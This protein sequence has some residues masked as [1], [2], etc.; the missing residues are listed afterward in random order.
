MQRIFDL[1]GSQFRKHVG[2]LDL[3]TVKS[4][5]STCFRNDSDQVRKYEVFLDLLRNLVPQEIKYLQPNLQRTRYTAEN[6]ADAPNFFQCRIKII[7]VIS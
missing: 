4:E 1:D 7:F 6:A 3:R 2:I 5:I